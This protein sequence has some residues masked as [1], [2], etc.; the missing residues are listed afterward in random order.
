MTV[1]HATLP[2]E[3]SSER[4]GQTLRR[5]ASHRP[6]LLGATILLVLLLIA[7]AAPL[8]GTVDPAALSPARR[9]RAPSELYWFGTDQLGRDIY[10]RVIYGTRISLIVGLSVAVLSAAAGIIV[11]MTAGYIRWTDGIIMRMMDGLMSIPPILLAI[12]LMTLTRGSLG[13]VILAITISEI[14]R[15][16]RVVRGA[17]LSLREQ[18]F[19]LAAVATGVSVPRIMLRH[20]LPNIMAPVIIQATYIC[21]AAMLTEAILSF[22][23]AG[24]PPTIPSWG[25]IMAEGR[26]LWQVKPYM[27]A[28]P[29][30][31]LSIAILAVNLVGDGLRDA[32]DPRLRER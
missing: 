32:L 18:P 17:L 9:N 8:L 7:V 20:I 2:L 29:A 19:V 22:I 6:L 30:I 11:G 14:P 13:N 23:G 1:E 4:R 16:A 28:F 27:I 15:V 26:A 10:S 12:A 5:L 21:G 3:V 31:F 25:N 24:L